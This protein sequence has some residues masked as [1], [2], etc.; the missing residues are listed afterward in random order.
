[1]D[2]NYTPIDVNKLKKKDSGLN[3]VLL[4]IVT[5]TALVL[6]ILLFVLI[7]KQLNQTNNPAKG[8]F[9]TRLREIPPR[10][11]SSTAAKLLRVDKPG[12]NSGDYFAS[13]RFTL[14]TKRFNKS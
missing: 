12:M 13:A 7:K 6:A 10:R 14:S 4:L 2:N 8:V 9:L 3:T 1:M 5:F 11:P